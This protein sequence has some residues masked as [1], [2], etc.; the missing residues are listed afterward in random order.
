M[1]KVKFKSE[2]EMDLKNQIMNFT[3]IGFSNIR[4]IIKD[5]NP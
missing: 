4:V 2:I 1:L 5:K 3:K